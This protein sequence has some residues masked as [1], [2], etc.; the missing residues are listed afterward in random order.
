LKAGH[1]QVGFNLRVS[2]EKNRYNQFFFWTQNNEDKQGIGERAAS[3]V[4][5]EGK[6]VVLAEHSTEGRKERNV[7]KLENL[8]S[9]GSSEGKVKPDITS[10]GRKYERYSEI[11]TRINGTPTTCGTGKS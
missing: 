5:Q 3:E 4:S 8:L 11:T 6:A 1:W 10:V 7:G 2:K 9:R